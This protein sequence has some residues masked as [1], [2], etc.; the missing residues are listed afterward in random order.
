MSFSLALSFCN[1]LTVTQRMCMAVS[2]WTMM[3]MAWLDWDEKEKKEQNSKE[4]SLSLKIKEDSGNLDAKMTEA[5]ILS[6]RNLPQ[7]PPCKTSTLSI[8]EEEQFQE[9]HKYKLSIIWGMSLLCGLCSEQA[10]DQSKNPPCSLTR[11]LSSPVEIVSTLLTQ[12]VP[13]IFTLSLCILSLHNHR[14]KTILILSILYIITILPS[15]LAELMDNGGNISIIIL[16]KFNLASIHII[17]EPV[18]ILYMRPDLQAALR[19]VWKR[20]KN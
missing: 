7:F 1:F 9:H 10:L 16:L 13:A 12:P 17:F 2:P 18:V 15:L 8:V 5:E 4:L 11:R 20:E 3:L 19:T 6:V 14:T